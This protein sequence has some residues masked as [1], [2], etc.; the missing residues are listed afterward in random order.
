MTPIQLPDSF[1]KARR[2]LLLDHPFFGALIMHLEPVVDSKCPT[3]WVDGVTLGF[4]P[5]FLDSLTKKEAAGVLA[6][7]IIHCALEHPLR[8]GSRENGIWNTATDHAV[9]PIVRASGLPLPQ[10]V[11]ENDSRFDGLSAEEIYQILSQGQSKGAEPPTPQQTPG[12]AP[13]PGQAPPSPTGE[14]RDMPG[15]RVVLLPQQRKV[16]TERSGKLLSNK[17]L[18][19]PKARGSTR[20]IWKSLSKTSYNPK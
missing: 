6:H 1:I 10:G 17:L 4:N 13:G 14:V 3:L 9:N 11:L 5:T 19:V 16:P 18:T 20:P 7:E 8:R 2:E 15:S 12:N